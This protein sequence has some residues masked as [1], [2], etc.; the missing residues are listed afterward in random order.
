MEKIKYIV[1]LSLLVISGC[2]TVPYEKLE[3]DTTSNFTTPEKGKAGV[4][5]YQWNIGV[6]SSMFD[7]DFEIKGYPELPVNTGEYGY[8]EVSPGYHEFKYSGGLWDSY[9]KILFEEGENYFFRAFLFHASDN[10]Y[11]VR[12]QKEID[13]AKENISSGR[14]ELYTVD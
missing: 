12:N 3:L 2:S 14:Y 13:E 8:F 1:L 11:L 6:I 10:A 5:V 4:Y 7:V 9:E